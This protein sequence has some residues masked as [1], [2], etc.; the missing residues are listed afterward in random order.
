[1]QDLLER[2]SVN[3]TRLHR[4]RRCNGHEADF[5]QVSEQDPDHT[6]RKVDIGS[7]IYHRR[8]GLRELHHRKVL[9]TEPARVRYPSLGREH[10]RDQVEGLTGVPRTAPG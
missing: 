2:I 5:T 7:D 10:R 6:E 4:N 8:W 9:R 1:M 3:L